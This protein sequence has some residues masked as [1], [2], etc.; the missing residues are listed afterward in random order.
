[1]QFHNYIIPCSYVYALSCFGL[2]PSVAS[3]FRTSE[4]CLFSRVVVTPHEFYVGGADVFETLRSYASFSV[5][6][7]YPRL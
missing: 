2:P 4:L 5:H 1:M 3:I 7:H 6:E